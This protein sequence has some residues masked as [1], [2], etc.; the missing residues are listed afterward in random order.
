M[1]EYIAPIDDMRFTLNHVARLDKIMELPGSEDIDNDLVDTIL[2]EAGK[3]ASEVFS[4]I[5]ASGDTNSPKI[6]NGVVTTSPGFKE[7]YQQFSENGWNSVVFNPEYGGQNFPWCL[8]MALTEMWQSSNISMGLCPVLTQAAIEAIDHHGTEEQRQTYLPSLISGEWTG[9]MNLTEPQAGT[10]LSSIRSIAK[11]E[12][13]HYRLTGQKIF[14]SYGEHDYTENIIHMVLAR[15]DGLP[16]GNDG[17]GLFLVPK[18]M[19]NTDGSLGERNEVKAVSLEHKMGLH[20]SP[21]CVM[22]YGDDKGAIA[23]LVGEEGHGLRNMFTM[24]NNARIFVGLQGLGICEG[25]YQ[26]ALAYAKDRIQSPKL[27]SKNAERVTII[28]HPDVKRMLLT[29]KSYTE[30][31]RALA[32][33]AGGQIDQAERSPDP[34]SIIAVRKRVDLLTPLVKALCT[35]LANEV[36]SLGIQVHGGMGF[37]EET[38]A[39]QYYRDARVL[40]IYEGTNGIQSMDLVFRKVLRDKGAEAHNLFNEMKEM[41]Q[42]IENKHGE[43]S[44]LCSNVLQAISAVEETTKWILDNSGEHIEE[45]AAGSTLYLRQFAMTVAGYLMLDQSHM[46]IHDLGDNTGNI[47]HLKS[48]QITAKFFIKAL[49]PQIHGL[50][51]PIMGGHKSVVDIESEQF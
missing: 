51:A 9:T 36:S 41:L 30:A 42:R 25:A 20:S 22:S 11:K 2:D 21:T 26:H 29:M 31:G 49:L 15:I 40:A 1:S 3:F 23:Y 13:D 4:P 7:A 39:A 34:E 48:K 14:I 35:D 17:M 8:A 19:V 5:N 27:G 28:E 50:S 44:D 16:E 18:F 6:S 46:S 45:V 32:Y 10:D 37:I 43:L 33:Y 24:M 12:D 38:G 47:E